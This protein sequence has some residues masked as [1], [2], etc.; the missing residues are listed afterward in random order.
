MTNVC[1]SSYILALGDLPNSFVSVSLTEYDDQKS[2]LASKIPTLICGSN[3]ASFG[4]S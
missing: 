2:K 4:N 1:H 3:F